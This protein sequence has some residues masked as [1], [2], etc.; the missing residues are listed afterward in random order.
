MRRWGWQRLLEHLPPRGVP[1]LNAVCA[2]THPVYNA[3]AG[4]QAR[5]ANPGGPRFQAGGHRFRKYKTMHPPH[6][7]TIPLGTFN[8]ALRLLTVEHSMW[9]DLP[10]G[11][12]L[13]PSGSVMQVFAARR[14]TPLNE[15]MRLRLVSTGLPEVPD[16]P[17]PRECRALLLLGDGALRGRAA[18]WVRNAA[19]W[20]PANLLKQPGPGMHRIRLATAGM[21]GV[22]PIPMDRDEDDRQQVSHSRTIGAL[23]EPAY[24]RATAL[25]VG[26][27]GTGRLGS[28][29]AE[30]LAQFGLR[31]LV[32]VDMDLVELSNTGESLFSPG[33]VGQSKVEALARRLTSR[34]PQVNVVAVPTSVTHLR[35]INALRE[36]DLLFVCPDHPVAR[37][38]AV[39][40]A[41]CFCIPMIDV[42]TRVF[43]GRQVTK[44]AD[45]RL[46]LPE[47]RCLLCFGG[48]E[49]EADGRRLLANPDAEEDFYARRDWRQERVG[50]LASVNLQAV[51]M[52]LGLFED[53]V[54]G[55][56]A[57]SSWRHLEFGADGG[58]TLSSPG[59]LQAPGVPCACAISGWGE[60]GLPAFLPILE[61]RQQ[62]AQRGPF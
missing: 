11:H 58:T 47:E 18:G 20:E 10:A 53:F 54:A 4:G 3:E 32:L 61:T 27:A 35:A 56:V 6:Q 29:L 2:I 16:S 50:S 31:H 30:R 17:L 21:E 14:A 9:V 28:H 49:N 34:W 8:R 57:D 1:R 59:A 13:H 44:Q 45:V 46:I 7:L 60:A 55:R 40:V 42:G 62:D 33:E 22:H 24:R 39:A 41:A 19:R 51:G 48:L 23:G 38:S 12:H 26:V 37:L 5:S 52:A 36:C 25:T 43:Q 15:E